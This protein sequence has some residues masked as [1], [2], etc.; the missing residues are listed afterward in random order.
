MV[1]TWRVLNRLGGGGNGTVYRCTG[2]DGAEAA[3]K[4]LRRDKSM[5]RDRIPRFRNEVHFLLT[6]GTCPGVLPLLDSALPDDPR[7]PSW[8]VMPLA[9]PLVKALKVTP[10]LT[11]IVSAVGQI[12]QTLARLAADGISHRDIKPDNLFRLNDEWVIGDF[13]LVK[14]PEQEPVTRHGKKVGSSDFMAPEMRQDAD[15]AN[16]ELADVYSMG[17]TLWAVAARRLDPPLGQLRRDRAELRLRSLN[18]S[19]LNRFALIGSS[20]N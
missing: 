19:A 10:G 12:S 5:P 15:T 14:Y 3:I 20:S 16:A 4:I 13:G 11:S 9:V 8:Y 18:A 17:K 6:R 7:Q 2:G 1:G